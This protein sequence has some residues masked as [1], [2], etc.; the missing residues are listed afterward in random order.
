MSNEVHDLPSVLGQSTE[1]AL[2][3]II[4]EG[5]ARVTFF[6]LKLG[7]CMDDARETD[8]RLTSMFKMGTPV[9]EKAIVKELQARAGVPDNDQPAFNFVDSVERVRRVMAA[10]VAR[11]N[12]R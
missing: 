8:R 10:R 3:H 12:Q 1:Y 9:L 6:H 4:G 2:N 5:G 7:E 11:G